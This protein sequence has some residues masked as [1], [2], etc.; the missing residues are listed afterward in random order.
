[1]FLTTEE[2]EIVEGEASSTC[3]CS[4]TA[5]GVG[6]TFQEGINSWINHVSGSP[7]LQNPVNEAEG[8]TA[9]SPSLCLSVDLCQTTVLYQAK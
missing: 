8:F 1:M 3:E 4:E 6:N 5:H 2:G 9:N 7:S